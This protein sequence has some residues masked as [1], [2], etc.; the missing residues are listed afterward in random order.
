MTVS[1]KCKK[2]IEKITKICNGIADW[3]IHRSP[4]SVVWF[5]FALI[6]L[7][8]LLELLL[9]HVS[10]RD[11]SEYIAIVEDFK[12][13]AYDRAF[14]KHLPVLYTILAGLIAK[15]SLLPSHL[16]LVLVSGVFTALSVFT[17]YA[18]LKKCV[19]RAWA[20]WGTLLLATFP[21]FIKNN[22]APLIDS[23]RTFFFIFSL[24]LVFTTWKKF[25][26]GRLVVLGISLACL[27]L[28]RAEG[29]LL[30]GVIGAVYIVKILKEKHSSFAKKILRSC[31]CVF[32]P[33][34]IVLAISYPRMKQMYELTGYPAIDSRQSNAIKSLAN[35][36]CPQKQKLPDKTIVSY[37]DHGGAATFSTNPKEI[38]LQKKFLQAIIRSLYYPLIPFT[39]FGLFLWLKRKRYGLYFKLL[40]LSF[41]LY[42]LVFF[43]LRASIARYLL[44]NAAIMMP[45]TLIG[46][47][48]ICLYVKRHYPSYIGILTCSAIIFIAGN[49][50]YSLHYFFENDYEYFKKVGIGL[51][52][53]NTG[54]DRPVVLTLGD[55]RGI[56]YYSN[57]NIVRYE[58]FALNEERSLDDVILNGVDSKYV[59]FWHGREIPETLY[60][61][62]LIIDNKK[63]ADAVKGYEHLFEQGCPVGR[64]TVYRVKMQRGN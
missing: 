32:F 57:V 7:Y 2:S 55:D 5:S 56:G 18:I 34:L 64:L 39:L 19:P 15:T 48:W 11:S 25:D 40:L 41:V 35:V 54:V 63:H 13:G 31:I 60:I 43:V 37:E 52:K 1:K 62:A 51:K 17:F 44:T 22:V 42:N 61:D 9:D 3:F 4:S 45:F 26:F 14:P 16:S 12:N 29:I 28:G 50:I 47:R 49:G 58:K 23:V 59:F 38:F 24:Y 30:T 53:C 20:A 33:L 10:F 6:L 46:C 27:T 21:Y 36:L 8:T